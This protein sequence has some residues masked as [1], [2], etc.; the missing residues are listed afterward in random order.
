MI[1]S[2]LIENLGLPLVAGDGG[3]EL[4]DLTD[5]SRRVSEGCLFIARDTGDD[6]WKTFAADAIERGAAALVVPE[7]IEVPPGVGLVVGAGEGSGPIDQRLAGRLS[8]RFFGEPAKRLKLI[9]ITGTNGKTTVATLSQYLLNA[10]GMKCGLIGTVTID[11]GSS[12]GPLTAELTT[13]GAID[14]HRHFVEMVKH[15]CGACAME[16]SSHALDQGR[17]DGLEFEVAVFTN[18]TQD[19]LDYHGTMENYAAAK[20]KL[21]GL[22]SESGVAVVNCEDEGLKLIELSS[23]EQDVV[24]SAVADERGHADASAWPS[25]MTASGSSAKFEGR[26]DA[27][28]ANLPL[29]GDYNLMNALQALTAAFALVPNAKCDWAQSIANCPPVPGRLERVQTSTAEVHGECPSVLVDY[30]HT[31]DALSTVLK[32]VHPL[33]KG[34]LICVFGCGGDRDRTKRPKMAAA[35]AEVADVL[36]LTSDNPRTEDPRQILSDTEAGVPRGKR[37]ALTVEID[38]A[39]AIESAILRATAND[40]VLIA[41]KGHEDYQILGNEKIHFDDREQAAAALAKWVEQHDS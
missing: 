28:D 16:V 11:H 8:A 14:L 29:T 30:A 25:E 12:E 22:L 23:V 2:S 33:T 38:R 19:H 24:L 39:M 15:G 20:A 21:L 36:F 18:L 3:L 32:T 31:P 9:G 13:P 1:L 26:W 4:S 10:A 6:R 5:D 35:V 40:T 41:G 37:E 17:V 27:F 7:A 34:K